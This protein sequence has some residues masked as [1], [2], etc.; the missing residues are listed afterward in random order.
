MNQVAN[1]GTYAGV[2]V[3]TLASL[4][5]EILLT[6]I[7][8]VTTWYHFAFVAISIAMF[9]MSLG[10]ILVYFQSRRL[11]MERTKEYMAYSSILLGATVLI[12]LYAQL[13]VPFR[14]DLTRGGLAS[15]VFTYSVISIPFV[16]SGICVCLALTR[17][18]GQI[19]KLYA[20]DLAGAASGC[21]LTI[22]VLKITDALTAVVVVALLAL[23][24][25]AWLADDAGVLSVR[26]ASLIGCGVL[27]IFVVGNTIQVNR[28]HPL[29]RLQWIKELKTK[30]PLYE[31]WN[32]YSRIAVSG[33]PDMYVIPITEGTSSTYTLNGEV[34]QL[35]LT[36][37]GSAE[38]TLTSYGGNFDNLDHL[39]DD[40]KEFVYYLRPQGSD[41][42]IGVGGGRDILAAL[43]LGQKSVRAV[44]VNGDVLR[45]VN[46]RFGD[47]T[48][49]LDRDPRV[50]FVNDEARSYLARIREQFDIIQ[51][52][53]IDTWAA[54]A[55]GGF[56]LTENGLYTTQAWKLFLR[57]LAPNGILSFSRWYFPDHLE[58]AYRLV[59][60]ASESLREFGVS[61]PRA[62]M[63]MIANV[64]RTPNSGWSPGVC[65]LLVSRDAFSPQD[66]G[67]A[68]EIAQRLKFDILL[69]PDFVQDPV[70]KALTTNPDIQK[71]AA[72]FPL[73]FSPPTDDRPFFFQ[74]V[75]LRDILL[76]RGSS[77]FVPY[78]NGRAVDVLATLL[79]TVVILTGLA[80][81]VPLF[82]RKERPALRRASPY[83]VYFA[84]IGLG[85]MLIEVSQMERLIV[86][87]GHP[88]YALSVVLFTLL[89]SSGAGSYATRNIG[90]EK[91]TSS[92]VLRLAIL[93]GVLLVTGAMTAGATSRF[94]YLETPE[95]ILVSF[96]LLFPMGFFM[97][98]AFPL[99]MM[100]ACEESNI[101]TPWLWGINGATSVFASVLAVA[102]ALVAGISAAYWWGVGAYAACLLAFFWM[103]LQS[104]SAGATAQGR[105]VMLVKG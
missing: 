6:R 67:R 73:D 15:A 35:Y 25:A 5:Y 1:K 98:M 45:A 65:T 62:H 21:A 13:H 7:F 87:L 36:I 48:G 22:Y 69:S 56:A 46:G 57:R 60:L 103:R 54:T 70:L 81:I 23:L 18:P 72:G 66:V 39:R 2:F 32:S 105:R 74:M 97:G 27:S 14:P 40:A 42:I 82:M 24:A 55:A 12:A 9:G 41:L 19:S 101:L 75:R 71:V 16:F 28:Q 37:D 59:S 4:M 104:R 47:F 91:W 79:V 99:G 96:A 94:A 58:E 3:V 33:D 30:P 68:E 86:F 49:H 89:L 50:T 92:G 90:K 61:D 78:W 52:S 64:R 85:Y 88:T 20:V 83:F 43:A 34:K 100:I 26:R 95:R 8:S 102:I 63:L 17:F 77:P 80:F 10:A 53:F 44:E 51:A 29:I 76:P 84:A 11:A 38:T 93:L 31:K